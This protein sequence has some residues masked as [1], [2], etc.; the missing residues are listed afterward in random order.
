MR[1]TLPPV[2]PVGVW[3]LHTLARPPG[4]FLWGV[5]RA[6]RWH[7]QARNPTKTPWQSSH[8]CAQQPVGAAFP[9]HLALFS[10]WGNELDR[11]VQ[12]CQ[13]CVTA[14]VTFVGQP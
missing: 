10:K 6:H 2:L 1:L 9:G 13:A 14:S 11:G 8:Q 3:P 12:N 5:G 7:S 4:D